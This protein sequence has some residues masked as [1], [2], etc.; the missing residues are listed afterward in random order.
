MNSYLVFKKGDFAVS[1]G[2][3]HMVTGKAINNDG[4]VYGSDYFNGVPLLTVR[5]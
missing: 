1:Y 5:N 2:V 4:V 3:N